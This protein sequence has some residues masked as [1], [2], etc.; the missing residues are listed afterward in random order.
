MRRSSLAVV[1]SILALAS[2][3]NLRSIE[4]DGSQQVCK[5]ASPK[6]ISVAFFLGY[7]YEGALEDI[8]MHSLQVDDIV[9]M[10]HTG[11]R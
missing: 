1:L 11:F 3:A 2:A 9:C 7:M 5:K 10:S 6:L 8:H 4:P